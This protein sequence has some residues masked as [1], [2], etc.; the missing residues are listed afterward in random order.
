MS[1]IYPIFNEEKDPLY[2]ITNE[3]VIRKSKKFKVYDFKFNNIKSSIFPDLES[4]YRESVTHV[5]NMNGNFNEICRVAR[6]F[7]ICVI[8]SRL[9]KFIAN[10]TE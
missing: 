4:L 3:K 1:D 7:G 2:F 10:S 5:I 8:D 9:N 6:I